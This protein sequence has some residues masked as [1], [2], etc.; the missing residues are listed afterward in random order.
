MQ[1]LRVD[2]KPSGT[3]PRTFRSRPLSSATPVSEDDLPHPH[4]TGPPDVE[5]PF[6]ALFAMKGPSLTG[7]QIMPGACKICAGTDRQALR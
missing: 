5:G 1:D 6:I 7:P 4:P 2:A 3:P